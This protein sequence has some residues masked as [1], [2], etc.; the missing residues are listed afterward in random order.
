MKNIDLAEL[1]G[2]CSDKR[3]KLA[4]L[5]K[6]FDL[7][8]LGD[9]MQEER[10]NEIYDTTLQENTFYAAE[11]CP[12]MGIEKGGRV[13][14]HKA[15]FL[16]SEADFSRLLDLAGVKLAEAGICDKDGNYLTNWTLCKIEARNSLVDFIIGE[17][18]P[19]RYRGLFFE[20][21]RNIT[22]MDKLIDITRPI[23]A[24]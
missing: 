23:L 20:N 10:I 19:K 5:F 16:L 6:A 14:S 7:A 11:E 1:V 3:E 15:D 2:N 18:I 21:R 8:M 12:R 9:D 24:K 22:Q 4:N 17:I 13:L